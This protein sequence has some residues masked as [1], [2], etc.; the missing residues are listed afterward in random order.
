VLGATG[1]PEAHGRGW[2]AV[3]GAHAH[4]PVVEYQAPLVGR[5]RSARTTDAAVAR[6]L[7]PALSRASE[8]RSA[9]GVGPTLALGGRARQ[10]PELAD[11]ETVLASAPRP[12][13]SDHA[14]S[15]RFAR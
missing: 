3:V 14:G 4:G 6:A 1:V 9:V 12:V 7:A 5:T 10:L 2:R 11:G 15:G 8:V 13:V